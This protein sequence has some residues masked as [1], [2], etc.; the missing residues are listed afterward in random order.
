MLP[1]PMFPPVKTAQGDFAVNTSAPL[2][3]WLVLKQFKS[4]A[5]CKKKLKTMAEFYRCVSSN[6]PALKPTP[7]PAAAPSTAASVTKQKK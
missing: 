7:T 2:S 5:A 3:K 1:P 4:Q 6:D